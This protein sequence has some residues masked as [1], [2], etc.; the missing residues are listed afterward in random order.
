MK[1]N[2]E[3]GAIIIHVAVA[4]I[5][6][7]GFAAIV[8]DYGAMWVARGQAQSAADAGALAGALTLLGDSTKTAEATQAARQFAGAQNAIWGAATA[9]AHIVVSPLPFACPASAGGG[10]SCIRVDVMRGVPDRAGA[11]HSNSL[12]T[13]FG[14][15]VGV[16]SQGVRATATAQVAAGNAVRCIKP[17][18]VAD[19]WI[20]NDGGTHPPGGWNQYDTFNPPTDGYAA[21]GFKATGANNDYGTQLVLKQGNVG[22][23][24]SGWTQQI[25]FGTTGSS[26][27]RAEI[28]GCPGYVPT[29]GLYDGSIPCSAR[30]DTA[31]PER[32]CISVKTGMA[33][34]PTSQGVADLIARDSTST[35]NTS[36]NSVTGGCM[37][38]ATCVDE[39]GA[40]VTLSP[41]IA[42]I[43][44]FNTSAYYNE[45]NSGA[46]SGTGCVA[47]VV[48][49]LGF[50]LE[51][52]C[53][54]VY[55]NV[56]TRPAYCG[57]PSQAN[58]AVVGRLMNYPGQTLGSAGPATSAAFLMITRLVQ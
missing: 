55:P 32:G 57:P 46:C 33:A 2:S 42:P 25:D 12:P 37:A 31:D 28:A 45:A 11:A 18:I 19:K 14:G 41:R 8:V 58:K 17:W 9:N 36:T 15:I 35:W 1:I 16:N 5:A 49:L 4:L 7:L 50:Y 47:Q 24:S 54:D 27:Y 38:S 30:G 21:P 3:R 10:N 56:A 29:V 13:F 26:A 23:W 6:L 48:N 52:M 51:G 53:N 34:G 39:Q 20:D 22:T 44:I 40:A 43:A